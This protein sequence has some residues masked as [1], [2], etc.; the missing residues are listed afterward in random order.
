M[1]HNRT[2]QVC[3]WLATTC[4]LA[5]NIAHASVYIGTTQVYKAEIV[6]IAI[7]TNNNNKTD[8]HSPA[9]RYCQ[10]IT[11][12]ASWPRITSSQL[13]TIIIAMEENREDP[14]A[15]YKTQHQYYCLQSP[16]LWLEDLTQAHTIILKGGGGEIQNIK[17]DDTR[18][19]QAGR[20]VWYQPV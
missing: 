12:H 15:V 4:M 3:M 1:Q 20:Q 14:L 11:S 19:K 6:A 7:D 2:T 9:T 10:V 8:V 17:V 18:P 16:R 5:Y 13:T